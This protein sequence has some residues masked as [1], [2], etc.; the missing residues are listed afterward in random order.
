MNARMKRNKTE[1]MWKLYNENNQFAKMTVIRNKYQKQTTCNYRRSCLF[2]LEN[3]K[4]V[5]ERN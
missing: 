2:Y 1:E 5:I 3:I 4:C